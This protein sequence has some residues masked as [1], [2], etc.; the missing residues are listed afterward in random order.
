MQKPI[1]CL[2][3]LCLL[4]GYAATLHAATVNPAGPEWQ[5]P[6]D[7]RLVLAVPAITDE[8]QLQTGQSGVTGVR[9]QGAGDLASSSQFGAVTS[10]L[11]NVASGTNILASGAFAGMSG[12]GV[13]IQNTGNSVLIQNS[14]ILNVAVQ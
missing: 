2:T 5:A 13:V 14:T 7:D 12:I 4:L 9:V 3:A 11:E 10:A 8:L 6:G 1:H